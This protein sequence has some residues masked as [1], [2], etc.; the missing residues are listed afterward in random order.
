MKSGTTLQL[1]GGVR[2]GDITGLADVVH[3]MWFGRVVRVG[4]SGTPSG[5]AAPIMPGRA[6]RP[7]RSPHW[8][9]TSCAIRPRKTVFRVTMVA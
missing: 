2:A 1:T 7:S 9:V 8:I 4:G 5:P 6:H 3:E